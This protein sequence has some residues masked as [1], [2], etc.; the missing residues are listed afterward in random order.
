MVQNECNHASELKLDVEF[1]FDVFRALRI[2]CKGIF[3]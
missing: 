2:E 1:R 3:D